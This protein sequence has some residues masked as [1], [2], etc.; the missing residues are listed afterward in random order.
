VKAIEYFQQAINLDRT[1]ALAYAGLADSYN[2]LS[3]NGVLP[4]KEAF[5]KAKEAAEKALSI[6][7]TLA[8][9]HTSLAF[10]KTVYDWDWAGAERS[11]KRAIEL[12]PNYANAHYFYAFAHLLSLGRMDEASTEI[13]RAL[14]LDPFSLIINTNHGRLLHFARQYDRAIEQYRKTLEMDPAFPRAHDRL[15]EAYEQ[16]GMYAEAIADMEKVNPESAARLKEAHARAGAQGYWKERIVFDAEQS[17]QAYASPYF[18]AVKYAALGDKD[19]A[20]EWLEKAYAERDTWLVSIKMDPMLDQ[21]RS[22][23]RYANLLQRLN[24]AP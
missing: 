8:E 20:F 16:K 4:P 3:T 11:F 7:D 22:D 14:E 12:N 24:I 17:R 10:I 23:P 9:A 1:Y 19:V 5:P 13:R 2:V 21:L 6:D 18:T 15:Q